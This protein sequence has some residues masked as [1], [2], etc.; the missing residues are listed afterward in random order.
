MVTTPDDFDISVLAPNSSLL[1][2]LLERSNKFPHE[3]FYQAGRVGEVRA[4]IPENS[5]PFLVYEYG[6]E[7]VLPYLGNDAARAL[8]DGRDWQRLRGTGGHEDDPD[9]PAAVRI[10]LGWISYGASVDADPD[11][12]WW[13]LFQVGLDRVP[14]ADQFYNELVRIIGITRLSKEAHSDLIRIYSGHD[15][16][17]LVVNVGNI[18]DEYINDWSGVFPDGFPA[19]WPKLSFKTVTTELNDFEIDIGA[20][21]SRETDIDRNVTHRAWGFV[22]NGDVINGG[23]VMEPLFSTGRDLE[24]FRDVALEWINDLDLDGLVKLFN[25]DELAQAFALNGDPVVP[26]MPPTV[27]T[28]FIVDGATWDSRDKGTIRDTSDR[29]NAFL[30]VGDVGF[31]VSITSETSMTDDYHLAVS[32][33]RLAGAVHAGASNRIRAYL[34]EDETD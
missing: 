1:M 28:E 13:D 29:G 26:E 20:S 10:G 14:D 22:I 27:Q 6:L 18:N 23:E 5:I 3:I 4:D 33:A 21:A 11:G 17:H 12:S 34:I 7:P 16:R 25:A 8:I 30:T 31:P 9:T 2:R 32:G 24:V 15:I 19:D